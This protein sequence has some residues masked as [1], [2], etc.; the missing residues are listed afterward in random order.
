MV[1]TIP[2][3]IFLFLQ[4]SNPKIHGMRPVAETCNSRCLDR[5]AK[6][7]RIV[8]QGHQ[9][10][11]LSTLIEV[12]MEKFLA[13]DLKLARVASG[14]S[15][16][17][18]AHLLGCTKER[19]SRLENAKARIQGHELAQLLLIYGETPQEVLFH[20]NAKLIE[21][22]MAR[23]ESIAGPS[24]AWDLNLKARRKTLE[25]LQTRLNNLIQHEGT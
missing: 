19:V 8:S 16:K 4:S 11:T 2:F 6:I 14:L 20:L 7:H 10:L 3:D 17:D 12:I 22:M 15:G 23:L 25:E 18:L 9:T 13:L 21:P 1:L 5:K 24:K